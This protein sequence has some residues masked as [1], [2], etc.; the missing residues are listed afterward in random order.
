[1]YYPQPVQDSNT[2]DKELNKK[3]IRENVLLHL[4][5]GMRDN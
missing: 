4:R 3:N 5:C 1:M 2:P